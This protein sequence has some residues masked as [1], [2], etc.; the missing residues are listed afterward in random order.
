MLPQNLI[1]NLDPNCG[2]VRKYEQP[3]TKNHNVKRNG[4]V[5]HKT[6]HVAYPQKAEELENLL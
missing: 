5:K 3:M 4:L 2:K 1:K 6:L